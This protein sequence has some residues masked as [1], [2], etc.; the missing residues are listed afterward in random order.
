MSIFSERPWDMRGSPQQQQDSFD[1]GESQRQATR[2]RTAAAPAPRR[3]APMDTGTVAIAMTGMAFYWL[4]AL[5]A[6]G[7]KRRRRPG[8]NG[9]NPNGQGNV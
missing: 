2:R 3:A 9:R 7:R 1:F 8:T 4:P 6:G 5:M